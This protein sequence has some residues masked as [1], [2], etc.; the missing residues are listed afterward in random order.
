MLKNRLSAI[1]S[2]LTIVAIKNNEVIDGGVGRAG[3][4]VKNSSKS[5]DFLK[6][7]TFRTSS[8]TGLSENLTPRAIAVED[9]KIDSSSIDWIENLSKSS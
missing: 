5:F 2:T 9:N 8:S 7:L 4:T 6:L 3:K 1:N